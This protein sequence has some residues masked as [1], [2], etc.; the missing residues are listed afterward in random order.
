MI[1]KKRGRIINIASAHGLVGSAFKSAYVAAKD[2]TVSGS[3]KVTA[4][5]TAELGITCDAIRPGDAYTPLVEAQID[6][7]AKAHGIP[8]E[9]SHPRCAFGAAAEQALR[10]HR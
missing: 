8:R 6:G 7:Q 2:G 9:R 4:L 3:T 1:A 10:H 5:E